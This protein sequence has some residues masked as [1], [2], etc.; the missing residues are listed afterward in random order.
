MSDD[1]T[2]PIDPVPPTDPTPPADP[3]PADWTAGLDADA[4]TYLETKG[5]KSPAEALT[6]LRG[7]EPPATADAYEIPVPE[8]ESPDFAKAVAPLFHKA[9][10]SATQAKALAEGWNEM[11]S[12]QKAAAAQAEADA[13]TAAEAAAKREDAA[14]KAEWGTADAA[15]REYARRAA[16]QFLPGDEAAKTEFIGEI[17]KKFGF[18]ATM[19]MWAAIGQGLGEHTA[20]GLGSAPA[21]PAKSWYDKSSMNP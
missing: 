17:E 7:Y 16:M 18:A 15:N 19:K 21:L 6:A 10:L 9:G 20:K 11:Q 5:F 1:A 4:K 8:G 2:P 13:A 3:P 14:L 12:G